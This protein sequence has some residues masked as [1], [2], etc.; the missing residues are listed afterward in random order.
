MSSSSEDVPWSSSSMS[1]KHFRQRFS[2]S[3]KGLLVKASAVMPSTKSSPSG[4]LGCLGNSRN[5]GGVAVV[6]QD[7]PE[8]E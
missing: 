4:V 3:G 2:R 5:V 7:P 1:L 6:A 8:I